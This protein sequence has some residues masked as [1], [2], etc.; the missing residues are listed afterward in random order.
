GFLRGIRGL[1]RV[2]GDRLAGLLRL[3]G[4]FLRGFLDGLGRLLRLGLRLFGRLVHRAAGL[5]PRALAAGDAQARGEGRAADDGGADSSRLHSSPPV[6][7][8]SARRSRTARSP[9]RR[10]KFPSTRPTPC[11]FSSVARDVPW[12]RSRSSGA[13]GKG[14]GSSRPEGNP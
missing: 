6:I 13:R 11:R 2:F 14:A 3:V 10:A 5:L 7:S 8:S 1:L 4:G 12:R 9:F